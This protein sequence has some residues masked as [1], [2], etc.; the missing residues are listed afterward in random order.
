M[1]LENSL[2]I[3]M[4]LSASQNIEYWQFSTKNLARV[5][6]FVKMDFTELVPKHKEQTSNGEIEQTFEAV[7]SSEQA[8]KCSGDGVCREDKKK[9]KQTWRECMLPNSITVLIIILAALL[10]ILVLYIVTILISFS[11]KAQVSSIVERYENVTSAQAQEI[12]TLREILE[13]SLATEQINRLNQT[14]ELRKQ[15]QEMN[16]TLI[17]KVIIESAKA[18]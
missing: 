13:K 7:D 3:V 16:E 1:D 15:I 9:F 17:E 4:S 10:C 2:L 5:S 12:A 11:F 14:K 18:R 8:S 6:S